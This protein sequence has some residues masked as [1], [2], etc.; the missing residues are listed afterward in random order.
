MQATFLAPELSATSRTV[1]VWI[2]ALRLH[3]GL[4]FGLHED[5]RHAPALLLRHRARLDDAHLV[6]RP[7]RLLLVV[8]LVL[9][10]LGHVLAVLA[11]L[12]AALD[13]D[14]HRLGHLG[15][16]HGP[17]A[18]L[19]L[20]AI[21]VR[22]LGILAHDFVSAGFASAALASAGFAVLRAALLVFVF[23]VSSV[24]IRAR[25]RLFLVTSETDSSVPARRRILR[26]NRFSR[27]SPALRLSSSTDKSFSSAAFISGSD[28]HRAADH[29]RVQGQL[30][31]RERHRLLG[32]LGGDAFHLEEDA[33]HL[34]DR[35]PLLDVALAVAHAG[36]GRLL[37]DG[38]VRKDPDPH[39][40]AALDEAGHGDAA[41]LELARGETAGLHHFQAV[42]AESEVA[43]A[44]GLALVAALLLLAE[45][46]AC[47][48]HHGGVSLLNRA[49]GG[50]RRHC[51]AGAG[52][53]GL[54]RLGGGLG[55]HF[56]AEDPHLAADL[57]VGGLGFREAVVDVGA[58]RVQRDAA[59]AV[60]LVAGHFGAAQAA[61]AGDPDALGAELLRGLDG[62][63]HRAAEGDAALELGGDVLG[64][65]LRVGLGLA[66]LDD[67]EEHLVLREGL[68]LLLDALDPGAALAD[69][70][71]GTRG[72][73][74]DLHLAG[75]ALDLDLADAGLAELLLHVLAQ[76][77]VLM[78]P[79]R[80]VLLLVPLGVP[81]ADDAEA[82]PDR[83][84]F[85]TH[86]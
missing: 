38:L 32:D 61:R 64:H 24:R 39:L 75:G 7:G 67:V 53:A 9:L 86:A 15:R 48:L 41:R 57:A 19:G 6:A 22:L 46:G 56:A 1:V 51:R 71:A 29:A 45:L 37:G 27:S 85:L 18:G 70:D 16:E 65:Q 52:G 28:V 60:P 74:V 30:V 84:D 73:H 36:F 81:R 62:L 83:I 76:A 47:W 78:E 54:L 82:E 40:A 13:L 33:A 69:D 58:E 14:D 63:L 25:S 5:L 43:A 12:H 42:V 8:A 2:M 34:H 11:V 21:R 66:D 35:V 79:A 17:D 26:L 50:G 31:R 10:L 77:D 44:V 59:F 23:W 55:E 68:Q 4:D 72:V 20:A 80:V 3:L 49:R